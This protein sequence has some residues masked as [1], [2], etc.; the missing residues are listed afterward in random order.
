MT[1]TISLEV[2]ISHLKGKPILDDEKHNTDD[3]NEANP[4]N[5]A[6][7]SPPEKKAAGQAEMLNR[8]NDVFS[9]AR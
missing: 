3:K 7:L 8:F 1:P 9:S 6:P 4:P 2:I 5:L